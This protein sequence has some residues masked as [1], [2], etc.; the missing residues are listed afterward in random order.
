MNLPWK[1]NDLNM[2]GHLPDSKDVEYVSTIIIPD[3]LALGGLQE[4]W[5]ECYRSSTAQTFAAELKRK[6]PQNILPFM[7]S[8]II[9][10]SKDD[11]YLPR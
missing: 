5:R 4:V 2:W 1:Q 9:N 6:K 10:Y 8:N 11:R 7:F 3:H